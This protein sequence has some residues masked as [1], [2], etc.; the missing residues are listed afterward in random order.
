MR[1]LICPLFLLLL[2]PGTN[3]ADT[4][5]AEWILDNDAST[6]TFTSIKAGTVAETHTF[7]ELAGSIGA[8]GNAS[9][10]IDLDSVDTGIEIRDRNVP[11]QVQL[12]AI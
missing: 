4:A 5:S 7:G 2:Y 11:V 10:V 9:L 6:L 1:M 12:W 8:D 3:S